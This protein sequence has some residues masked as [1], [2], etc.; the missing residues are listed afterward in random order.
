M[1]ADK[2]TPF[3]W[4]VYRLSSADTNVLAAVASR[5]FERACDRPSPEGK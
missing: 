5:R 4:R 1:K 3:Y 2:V